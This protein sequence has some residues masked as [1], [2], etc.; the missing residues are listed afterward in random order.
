MIRLA[1]RLALATR[2]SATIELALVAPILATM[3]MGVSDISI[4]Y[5]KKLQLEQAAQRAIEKVAQTT[6]EATPEDTIKTEAKCQYNGT[7]S[8]VCKTTPLG[9][10]NV[11]VDGEVVKGVTVT[12][13]LTCNGVVTAYTSDC[14]STQTEV[15]YISATVADTYT[16]MFPIKFGTED[17]GSYHLTGIAGV[18]VQ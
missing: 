7:A 3:V 14:T 16:P 15:R 6:G 1:K 17:D 2:G 12:Y 5:G 4:A 8:G 18:R 10:A 9:D 13:S 11:T